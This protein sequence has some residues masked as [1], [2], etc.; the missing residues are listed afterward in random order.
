MNTE[1]A[2]RLGARADAEQLFT[3]HSSLFTRPRPRVGHI[4]FLNCLPLYHGLVREGAVLDMELTQGTP[5]ELNR[6]LLS[7]ALDVA[8]ISSVEYLRHAGE[9]LLLPGLTVASDG[10]VKSIA[11]VSRLPAAALAGRSVA[12][13]DTS[14]TSQVLTRIVLAE[15]YGVAPRFFAC[16]PDLD[17]MLAQADAALLIG[18]PALHVL[19][20]PPAG[21]YCYDLGEEWAA[22]TGCAMVYAVWAVRREYAAQAPERVAGVLQAFDRSLHYSLERIDHIASAVARWEPYPAG[23]LAAYFR[24]LR[25]EFGPRFRDGLREFARRAAVHGALE[26]VPALGFFSP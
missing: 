9:L 19:W 1:Q 2:E 20:R 21:L 15:R 3:L 10:P 5:T 7:G 24:T 11:L 22:L 14:A 18:D 13:T 17:R 8:P 4:R 25:F 23:F 6:L 26:Q 12:L 16:P